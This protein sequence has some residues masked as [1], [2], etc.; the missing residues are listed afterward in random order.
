MCQLKCEHKRVNSINN[1]AIL[2]FKHRFVRY[3]SFLNFQILSS[4]LLLFFTYGGKNV[5][6]FVYCS[7]LETSF[8]S[9]GMQ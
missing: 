3:L 7:V 8:H 4:E 6:L 9:F 2:R 5:F 1:N